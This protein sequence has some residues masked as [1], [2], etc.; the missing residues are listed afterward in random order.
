MTTHQCGGLIDDEKHRTILKL[1]QL[2]EP[3][4]PLRLPNPTSPW[5]T[6]SPVNKNLRALPAVIHRINV[7]S[8]RALPSTATSKEVFDGHPFHR[9]D[10]GP[11]S[12]PFRPDR[13][14][15]TAPKELTMDIAVLAIAVALFTYLLAALCK[16]EW[17]E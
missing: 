12:R 16:P 15:R 10:S 8:A 9:P 14:S 7:P 2:S 1:P 11:G 17:F 13:T 6:F 4:N 5:Q 3:K